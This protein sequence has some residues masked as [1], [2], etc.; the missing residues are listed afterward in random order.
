MK[1]ALNSGIFAASWSPAD[2]LEAAA[3]AGAAGLELNIDANALWTQRLDPAARR[4]LRQQARDA[5]VA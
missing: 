4:A 2:K 3:R 1:I 5:E